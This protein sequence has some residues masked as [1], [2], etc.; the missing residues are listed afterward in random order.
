[1]EE[2]RFPAWLVPDK[3]LDMNYSRFIPTRT[4]LDELVAH[5]RVGRQRTAISVAGIVLSLFIASGCSTPSAEDPYPPSPPSE[6]STEEPDSEPLPEPVARWTCEYE[7][8]MNYDWHD[9]VVCSNGEDSKRPYLRKWD[10]FV[11]RAEIMDSA[12]KYENKLNRR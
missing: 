4:P 2:H 6:P 12:R 11:T 5:P 10:D 7:P 3:G 8:T 9:D 1:M